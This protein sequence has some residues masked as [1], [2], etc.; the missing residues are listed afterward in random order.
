MLLV[1]ASQD[2]QPHISLVSSATVGTGREGKI[3]GLT[4]NK[5]AVGVSLRCHQDDLCIVNSHLAPHKLDIDKRNED[6]HHICNRLEFGQEEDSKDSDLR[7]IEDHRMRFWLGDLN[8]RLNDLRTEEVKRLVTYNNLDQLL[9]HHDQLVQERHHQA[10]FVGW[11]EGRIRFRPTYKYD[12]G[13][14]NWDSSEK[15]R[16]PAWTDRIL[17]RGENVCQTE[18]RSHEKLN[19]SDHKPVSASFKL[20]LRV[21]DEARREKVREKLQRKI[22]EETLFNRHGFLTSFHRILSRSKTNQ[23]DKDSNSASPQSP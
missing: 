22:S 13:S 12:I 18:Y 5:G 20:G 8:Y 4:G 17:W 21:I 6:F 10:V 16:T 19:A 9:D 7:R 2:L 23:K 3:V 15:C 14:N 11:S 1:F